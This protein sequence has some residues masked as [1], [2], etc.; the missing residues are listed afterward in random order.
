M[1]NAV[2]LPH[3]Y[4]VRARIKPFLSDWVS[5]KI[6][7]GDSEPDRSII[8]S[9][10]GEL[11]ELSEKTFIDL[12][13]YVL[14]GEYFIDE[15]RLL[16][17]L[18]NETY[19]D[20]VISGDNTSR[21][22]LNKALQNTLSDIQNSFKA[23]RLYVDSAIKSYEDRERKLYLN[24][25]P[26]L[27]TSNSF[28]SKL[29]RLI[30]EVCYKEFVFSYDDSYI[31]D[32]LTAKNTLSKI[33]K[34]KDKNI[35][36]VNIIKAVNNK[37]DFL[38][39]KLSYYSEK[40]S[41]DTYSDFNYSSIKLNQNTDYEEG[42]FRKLF[43]EFNNVELIEQKKILSWQIESSNDDPAMWKYAFLMRYYV[44]KTKNLPIIDKLLNSS[45][46][47]YHDSIKKDQDNIV[48]K[49]ADRSMRNYMYNSRFSYL[50]Q[51]EDSYSFNS[52]KD[53]LRNIEMVQQETCMYSYHPYEKAIIFLIS[54]LKAALKGYNAKIEDLQAELCFLKNCFK[55]FKRNI[56]WCKIHQPYLI[57]MRFNFSL[58]N[59][60][61]LNNLKVFYPSSFC[62][63]LR[64]SVLEE[65][66]S[67]YATDISLIEYQV[68]HY[69]ESL[70]LRNAQEK[71]KNM[72]KDSLKNLGLFT[73][74]I[75]FLVGLLTIFIGN[76]SSVSIFS[77]MEYVICLGSLVLLFVC[78]G[79]FIM[80]DSLKKIKPYILIS[81]TII[82]LI[83][84]G[85]FFVHKKR[86]STPTNLAGEYRIDSLNRKTV[87]II[88]PSLED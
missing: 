74:V 24:S 19:V 73:S 12:A 72:E 87:Q 18:I 85:G 77:K 5:K 80:E 61:D 50:C 16:R 81:I 6:S 58:K 41:I 21:D 27:E 53:D 47:H 45:E 70:E 43:L 51:C 49:Y 32:L 26:I 54:S 11:S 64:F 65:S 37:I 48:N 88:T 63:P 83:F 44:K 4:D 20:I 59:E 84:L 62:R 34:D 40:K 13:K 30:C 1:I 36:V 57:Q 35:D 31:T 15:G 75:T 38:V 52:L 2:P 67:K 23:V 60:D 33:L 79:Y 7:S 29:I 86:N 55:N 28:W 71:I 3:I 42:D 46:I 56:Q 8:T 78:A 22:N 82:L 17:R 14:A 9:S 68:D 66:L 10:V 76:N 69:N 25:I 39:Q